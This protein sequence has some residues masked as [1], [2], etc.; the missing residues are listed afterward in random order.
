MN[1]NII[2]PFQLKPLPDNAEDILFK[3]NGMFPTAMIDAGTLLGLV[4]DSRLIPHDTDLDFYFYDEL[5]PLSE[6]LVY[7]VSHD[8][9]IMQRAYLVKGV[10]VDFHYYWKQG[11]LGYANIS[12]DGFV[13]KPSRFVKSKK[14][15]Y[16]D[17]LFNIPELLDEYL[18]WRFGDWQ[19]PTTHK[20]AWTETHPNFYKV[21]E[22]YDKFI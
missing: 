5:P 6:E 10:L 17:H 22:F 15:E 14:F 18:V 16:K 7:E 19:T 3:I 13:L 4:R 21:E 20:V 9:I 11:F 8:G 12:Q 1:T 2:K